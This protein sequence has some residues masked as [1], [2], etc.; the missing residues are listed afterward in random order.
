MFMKRKKL[1]SWS[2]AMAISLLLYGGG[3][4][5]AKVTGVCANCHTM[6]NSQGGAVLGASG[7]YETLLKGDCVGCH[8]HVSETQT[9]SLGTSIV[10]VVNYTGGSAP[11]DHLAGGNFYW[12]AKDTPATDPMGHNVFGIA[13]QDSN[14]LA[15]E[16][17][18]GNMNSC[19]PTA[20]HATL[21]V[22]TT[23]LPLVAP[24]GCQ[25]CHL[26]VMHHADDGTGTKYV[27]TGDAGWYRFLSGHMAANGSGV[28]G[29]E[30]A[31]WQATT[32]GPADHNE[33]LGV[34]ATKTGTTTLTNK[35]MS[36]FCCGCHGN[37]HVEQDSNG[38]WIRHPSDAVI[39]S[40]GEY[41]AMSI[42]YDPLIPLARSAT[43]MTTLGD[44]PSGLV[45]AG[46]DMVMC[47]SCHRS[48]G[49]PYDDLLRWDYT[50][51]KAGDGGDWS[52]T[53]CFHCHTEKD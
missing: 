23:A 38:N 11:T 46:T 5:Y 2:L 37:F 24:G 31:D 1:L 40:S 32:A 4:A 27:G 45:A 48:H 47:L 30:D 28:A 36:A 25:G 3:I 12:V 21:A 20:C 29:I 13:S 6:H 7:P 51:M 10:P 9:Y 52:G 53:G 35:S 15:A 26:N 34:P 42:V 16:E 41:A 39:P 17:A 14:I 8:S 22:E 18:P 50:K 33:Y 44:S 49:S 43:A 19:G